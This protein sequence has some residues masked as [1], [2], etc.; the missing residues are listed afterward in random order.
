MD[1][2]LRKIKGETHLSKH[3]PPVEDNRDLEKV[4]LDN[5]IEKAIK[6]L[7]LSKTTDQDLKP[8]QTETIQ[9]TSYVNK[10]AEES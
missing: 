2:N 3:V 6:E 4:N 7:D 8:K 5:S 1:D 9:V 10:R